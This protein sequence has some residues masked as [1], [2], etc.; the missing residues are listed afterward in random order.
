MLRTL[1]KIFLAKKAFSFISRRTRGGAT[2][3]Y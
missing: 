3:R 2:R 1:A